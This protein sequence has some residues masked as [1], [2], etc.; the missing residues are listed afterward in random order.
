MLL[1]DGIISSNDLDFDNI[2]L[3][4]ISYKKIHI[5]FHRVYGYIRKS[6]STK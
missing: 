1:F 5:I 6:D 2:L 3:D 4:D